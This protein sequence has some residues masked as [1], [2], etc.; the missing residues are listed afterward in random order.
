MKRVQ[1]IV[2][3]KP[4]KYEEYKKLHANIWEEAAKV[5]K[6]AHIQ[7]YSISYRDGLLFAYFEYTGD[8]YEMDMQKMADAEITKEWW[9][10]CKPCL[11]PVE[12]EKVSDCWAEMEE[13][14]Y[15]K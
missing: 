11:T 10:V 2:K 14:F 8:N 7:N 1:Q 9:A 12:T 3:V 4:E 13:I 15:L 5:I 6:E